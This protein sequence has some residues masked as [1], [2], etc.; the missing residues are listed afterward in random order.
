MM[1][2]MFIEATRAHA[3][4]P[5]SE[6]AAT[7]VPYLVGLYGLPLSRR[8]ACKVFTTAEHKRPAKHTHAQGTLSAS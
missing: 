2:N 8:M 4:C 7:Q 6:V 5:R 1:A 3:Y